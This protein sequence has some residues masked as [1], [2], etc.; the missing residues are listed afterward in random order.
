M[1]CMNCGAKLQED[2]KFCMNC[3][4]AVGASHNNDT[5]LVPAKCTNCNASLEVDAT[6]SAAICPY[7]KTPYIVEQAIHNYNISMSGNM[8]I[9]NATININNGMNIDN[10][11]KRAQ[12]FETEGNYKQAIE[13]YNRVLDLDINQLEAQNCINRIM[14]EIDDYV[15][16]KSNANK[17]FTFGTLSLKKDKLVFTNKSGKETVYFLNRISNPRVTMGCLGFIYDNKATETSYAVSEAKKWVELVKNAQNGIYPEM[18]IS[19]GSDALA[20]YIKANFD[21]NSTVKAIKYCR[22]QTGWGLKE[23]KEYVEN[24]L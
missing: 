22:E 14:K 15:Y 23:A 11:M 18:H 12:K 20:D 19:N 8:N 5:K 7:C 17:V 6:Q 2:A 9:N 24:I 4:M 21:R 16:F 13:Y 1:F 3:G 10:L